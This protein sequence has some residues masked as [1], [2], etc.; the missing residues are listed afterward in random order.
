[1]SAAAPTTTTVGTGALMQTAPLAAISAPLAPSTARE[2]VSSRQRMIYAAPAATHRG[3]RERDSSPQRRL[4]PPA[5]VPVQ[6]MTPS[7]LQPSASAPT[8]AASPALQPAASAPTSAYQRVT[9]SVAQTLRRQ[10][11]K[12]SLAAAL[13]HCG[14]VLEPPAMQGS[15]Y[16]EQPEV[17]STVYFGPQLT[18]RQEPSMQP[19][20]MPYA[21]RNLAPDTALAILP[22]YS[23]RDL[24]KFLA[25]YQESMERVK[26]E[27]LC[28]GY[29]VA[30]SRGEQLT[31][32][33]F[34]ESF[35]SAEGVVAHFE[36]I[37]DLMKNGF[38]RYGELVS[39]QIH[40]PKVEIDKLRT[41]PVVQ[42][43]NP[44]FY[45][46]LP[47]SFEIIELP[48]QSA[49]VQEVYASPQVGADQRLVEEYRYNHDQDSYDFYQQPQSAAVKQAPTMSVWSASGYN[50]HSAAAVQSNPPKIASQ[51]Q[52]QQWY[53]H[54]QAARPSY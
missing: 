15:P 4:A 49:A 54:A 53:A 11:S 42:E 47:Q 9:S 32:A 40:G 30:I 1:M 13:E 21:N 28:L 20:V 36:N 7:G 19:E 35:A 50:S 52:Q 34:R 27:A 14:A 41:H 33:F 23:V 29:G 5:V 16:L 6:V 44:D 51:Q 17:Q 25:V 2:R 31:M 12:S 3:S 43:M 8:I 10:P 48:S 38:C 39:M 22:F 46:L 37:A 45:E 26:Q 24:D 18:E